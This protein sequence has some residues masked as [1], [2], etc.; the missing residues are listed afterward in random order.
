MFSTAAEGYFYTSIPSG[1]TLS[2]R[3][4][5]ATNLGLG[6]LPDWASAEQRQESSIGGAI[7]P[8]RGGTINWEPP[9]SNPDTGLFLRRTQRFSLIYLT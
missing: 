7:A 6:L 3:K 5:L 1:S 4:S 8:R 2:R 9:A